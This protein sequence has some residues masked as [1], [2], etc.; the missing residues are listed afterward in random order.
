MHPY[1]GPKEERMRHPKLMMTAS[2]LLC[3]VDGPIALAH[4]W[5]P[6][7]CCS[8]RDCRP[9]VEEKGETVLETPDGW[10]LWDGRLIERGGARQSPDRQ[11]HIC[12][13]P[14]TKAIICFFAP[15][16]GS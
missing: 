6:S 2:V 3:L 8:D 13:E 5:Y 16:G 9:L 7:W 11:F 14:T 4:D 15:V 12:E 10:R 1:V